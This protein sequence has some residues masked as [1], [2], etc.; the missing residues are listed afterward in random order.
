MDSALFEPKKTGAFSAW[1][2][3]AAIR[4]A[5]LA[6]TLTNAALLVRGFSPKLGFSRIFTMHT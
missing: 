4:D 5:L 6:L 3:N 1:V 2:H